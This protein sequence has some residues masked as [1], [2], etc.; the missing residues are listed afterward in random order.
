MSV[1]AHPEEDEVMPARSSIHVAWLLVAV[2][3]G[4]ID[5]ATRPGDIRT[6]PAHVIDVIDG[7]TIRV[8]LDGD[9][10]TVRLIGIDTPE[11]DGPYTDEECFGPEA[12]AYAHDRLDDEDVDLEFD[13]ERTDRYGRTLAYVWIGATLVNAD[14]V[15]GG[16]ALTLTIP[17]NVQYADAL[18]RAQQGARTGGAGLWGACRI[19]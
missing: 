16:Y 9:E 6:V 13:V 15:R 4:P 17:P 7:D 2:A 5:S 8:D 18:A 14:L 11:V 19:T 1:S 10:V 3:C 12:S